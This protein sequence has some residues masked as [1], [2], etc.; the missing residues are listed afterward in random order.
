MNSY[1]RIALSVCIAATAL[2][3]GTIV[4]AYMQGEADEWFLDDNGLSTFSSHEALSDFVEASS[5]DLNGS[6]YYDLDVRTTAPTYTDGEA[7]ASYSTT[8]VQVAGIDESDIVKTD[9]EYVYIVSGSSVSIVKAYPPNQMENVS[10]LTLAEILGF[11][12]VNGTYAWISGLFLFE[13]KLVVVLS[14]YEWAN[15]YLYYDYYAVTMLTQRAVVSVLDVSDAGNP[16]LDFSYGISGY[17]LTSRM[18]DSRLY[19]VARWGVAMAED[20]VYMPTFW[21]GNESSEFDID[22]IRYD[23]AA[24]DSTS[25]MNLLAVDVLTGSYEHSSVIASYASVVYMSYEALYLTIQKWDG[26]VTVAEIDDATTQETE[27]LPEDENSAWTSIYKIRVS[28]LSMTPAAA[29]SVRG[30]LLNQF[31]LDEYEQNLRVA[32]TTSWEDRENAVYVLDADLKPVGALTGLAPEESIYSARFVDDLLYLVTFRVIDPLFVIDLSNPAKPK[33]IGEL[34]IPGFSSYLHPVDEDH[35]L[36]I[37][38]ENSSVKITLFDVSDPANPVEQSTYLVPLPSYTLASYDHK[39]VL[40][41]LEKELLVVPVSVLY[42]YTNES[43]DPYLKTGAYV[44]R[45]SMTDGISLRGVIVHDETGLPIPVTRSLYIDDVLYTVSYYVL[46]ANS[47]D[48]LSEQGVLIYSA[49]NTYWYD[50]YRQMS[51]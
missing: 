39:A 34:K 17:E 26:G 46:K 27:I 49:V 44:F 40:F 42:Y 8:N 11:D 14:L 29:G 15:V 22:D 16:V 5:S 35:V 1:L 50:W 7:A 33:V 41:D 23:P 47:L 3:A 4:Y 31:S 25:F 2:T 45:V 18:I 19:L 20:G 48:D 13:N 21:V 38:S 6:A 37:G 10:V 12:N 24:E 30:W 9:G 36:G 51:Y 32:T 28:G 43:P